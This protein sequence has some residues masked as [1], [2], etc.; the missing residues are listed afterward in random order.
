MTY[1]DKLFRAFQRLHT[2]DQFPGSGVGL[3]IVQRVIHRHGGQTW[4][5]AAE[6]KGAEFSFTLNE[7]VE[8]FN[9]SQSDPGG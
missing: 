2:A 8:E 5:Q 4:A 7:N 6:G 3:A 9:G 1:V